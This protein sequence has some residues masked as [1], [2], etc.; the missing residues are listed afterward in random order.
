MHPKKPLPSEFA[1]LL[2]RSHRFRE[3]AIKTMTGTSGR[4]RVQAQ[5]VREFPLTQPPD[6]VAAAFGD[7][8]RPLAAK[9]SA[10]ARESRSLAALHETLLPKLISGELRVPDAERAMETVT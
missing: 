9:A 10:E 6:R 1:Y 7:L 3:F 5:A 8:V 2:A 4:Q